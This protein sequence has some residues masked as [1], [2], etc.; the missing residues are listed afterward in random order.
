[1]E[2]C[3]LGNFYLTTKPKKIKCTGTES[4]PV[5]LH[6]A[7]GILS[8]H[9]DNPLYAYRDQIEEALSERITKDFLHIYRECVLCDIKLEKGPQTLTHVR[10]HGS[11]LGKLKH[12][13]T[14]K[15]RLAKLDY[16]SDK[17]KKQRSCSDCHTVLHSAYSMFVHRARNHPENIQ[18]P[19]L[20]L[21]CTLPLFDATFDAHYED[22]HS[23]SCCGKRLRTLGKYIQHQI[24]KHPRKM[25]KLFNLHELNSLYLATKN[26]DDTVEFPW[27]NV[28]RMASKKVSESLYN[29]NEN[30]I[31]GVKTEEFRDLY[32]AGPGQNI[33]YDVTLRFISHH[34]L[35]LGLKTAPPG[36]IVL[37]IEKLMTK[38][39]AEKMNRIIENS[40]LTKQNPLWTEISENGENG[41]CDDCMERESHENKN[42]CIDKRLLVNMSAYFLYGHIDEQLFNTQHGIVIGCSPQDMI[43]T[44]P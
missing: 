32:V 24:E 42:L 4:C 2:R 15:F 26:A 40:D 6:A 7:Q 10:Q 37:E 33:Y 14:V 34:K 35:G 43:R 8:D 30:T 11:E 27:G 36:R 23:T 28:S 20:C 19:L 44:Y 29:R 12:A 5:K 18:H 21:I 22:C 39:L 17:D 13:S 25:E 38:K 9:T 31:P 3:D 41:I 16:R 1:M